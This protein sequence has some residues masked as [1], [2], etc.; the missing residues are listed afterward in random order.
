MARACL[1]WSPFHEKRAY[2]NTHSRRAMTTDC[3]SEPGGVRGATPAWSC[4]HLLDAQ[5]THHDSLLLP[6]ASASRRA[7]FISWGK[8][9]RAAEYHCRSGTL[10]RSRPASPA[11]AG[12]AASSR[13]R[14]DVSLHLRQSLSISMLTH[15]ADTIP[16]PLRSLPERTLMKR[17]IGVI[18]S[19]PD[20]GAL[21]QT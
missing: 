13:F 14:H 5:P 8:S 15:V 12:S 3:R 9:P 1:R 18:L 19:L 11:G 10:K 16:T 7:R 6:Q 2:D 4:Q 17:P 20:A 21:A